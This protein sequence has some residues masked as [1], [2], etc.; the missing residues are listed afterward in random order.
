MTGSGPSP[1]YRDQLTTVY[2]GD[3]LEV[4]TAL[5]GGS[6]DALVTDPPAGIGFMGNGW[7][8]FDTRRPR[9]DGTL[10]GRS[11]RNFI[12]FMTRVMTEC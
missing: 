10:R 2:L 5:D 6:I 7:D 9:S 12:D 8:H 3:C 11:R 4:L 1:A